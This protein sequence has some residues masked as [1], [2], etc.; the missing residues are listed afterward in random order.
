MRDYSTVGIGTRYS[1]IT[2]ALSCH[3]GRVC[4]SR[5]KVT[6]SVKRF[7]TVRDDRLNGFGIKRDDSPLVLSTC[8]CVFI[9]VSVSCVAYKCINC[10]PLLV[11]VCWAQTCD[12][13]SSMSNSGTYCLRSCRLCLKLIEFGDGADSSWPPSSENA[14][15]ER[16][17]Q[18]FSTFLKPSFPLWTT[19]NVTW[20]ANL[21]KGNGQSFQAKIFF[22]LLFYKKNKII[23]Y[24]QHTNLACLWIHWQLLKCINFYYKCNIAIC[25]IT[26]FYKTV[27]FVCM[28]HVFQAT[29]L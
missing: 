4:M 22:K 11:F 21:G 9:Q 7:P 23:V 25:L 15:K 29:I 19:W 16:N 5:Q 10:T 27:H 8:F 28:V 2:S 20:N 6:K 17:V 12:M 3:T 14:N 18:T 26:V 13:Q 24:T 1:A